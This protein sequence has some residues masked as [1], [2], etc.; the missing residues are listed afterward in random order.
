MYRAK[1]TEEKQLTARR[2][3]RLYDYWQFT[4]RSECPGRSGVNL[5]RRDF[6]K[7]GR[8]LTKQIRGSNNQLLADLN[9]KE[10]RRAN[11]FKTLTENILK[12]RLELPVQEYTNSIVKLLMNMRGFANEYSLSLLEK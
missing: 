1:N 10:K 7:L 3:A 2:Q 5:T 8:A 6:E 11:I 9:F 12:A 4:V